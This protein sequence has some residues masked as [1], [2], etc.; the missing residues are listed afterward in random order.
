MILKEAG[1]SKNKPF[2]KWAG[3]KFNC[4]DHLLPHFKSAKRLI[5][6]FAGSAAV[7]L[8]TNYD[9]YL[10]AEENHDLVYLLQYVQKDGE[11]FIDECQL[12]FTQD[13]NDK[14]RYYALRNEFN[15]CTDPK[16][17]AIYFLY[18]NRHGYNG[19]CR[20]NNGGGYNVPFGRYLKPLF[21]RADMLF[22]HKKSQNSVIIKQD[23]RETFKQAERGDLIYCDPPYV[24]RDQKSNFTSYTDQKFGV[25]DQID[26]ANLAVEAA[27][28]GIRVIISNHDTEFTRYHYQ[29]AKI[30]SFAIQRSISCNAMNREIVKE[31]VAVF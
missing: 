25:S 12:L 15:N 26:L 31:I 8:N 18:L 19:L 20:Y 13:N 29:Q 2:L 11:S 1:V 16:Q 30:H 6:P 28:R 24:P 5:E 17:R 7:F 10:L 4:L 27:N 9:N 23:F 21:P 3:R 14:D 22:F